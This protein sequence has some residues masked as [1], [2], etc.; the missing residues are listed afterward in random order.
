MPELLATEVLKPLGLTS[1]ANSFTPDIPAPV[2]HAFTSER[3]EA[4]E[5]PSGTPFYEESTYWNPSWTITH[6]AIQTT[7][8]YDMEATAAAIGSGRLL[9]KESYALMTSTDLRGRTRTQPGCTTCAELNE[10]YTYGLGIVISGDWLLQNPLFAGE[11]GVA[12]YLPSRR[13]A[14]A[15]AVTYR[16]EAFDE[17]GNYVNAADELFRRVGAELAPDDAPPTRPR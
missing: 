7:N 13:I 5:I 8:I 10:G 4:L 3:R 12:A 6:G 9:S 11:A 16:P 15:V 14:I 17:Q 2:L 1:T